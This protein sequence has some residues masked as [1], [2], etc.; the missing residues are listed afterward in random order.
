MTFSLFMALVACLF[1]SPLWAAFWIL[2][3]L[4]PD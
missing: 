1:G 4:L 3:H 2:V